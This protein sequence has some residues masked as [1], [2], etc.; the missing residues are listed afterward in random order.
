MERGGRLSQQQE[1]LSG[2]GG[3]VPGF[4]RVQQGW[5]QLVCVSHRRRATRNSR[6]GA[7]P[8]GQEALRTAGLETGATIRVETSDL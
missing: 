3:G 1:I 4:R 2:S 6:V 5:E 7:V 8:E